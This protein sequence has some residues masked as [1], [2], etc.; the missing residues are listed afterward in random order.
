MTDVSSRMEAHA[1][2]LL[3]R[4]VRQF[5]VGRH[6]RYMKLRGGVLQKKKTGL[7]RWF[8][9]RWLKPFSFKEPRVFLLSV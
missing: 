7:V 4:V 6:N 2:L 1:K 3:F 9:I 8:K 5:L